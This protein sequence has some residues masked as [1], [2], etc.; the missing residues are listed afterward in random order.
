MRVGQNPA[1][2]VE[3]VVQPQEVT[4]AVVVCIPFLSG[5]FEESL[6]VLKA[7][8]SSI[9]ENT[10]PCYDLMVFDNASCQEVRDYLHTLSEKRLIQYLVFSEKNIGKMGAWNFIFGAAPGT[11]IAYAD[12]DIYFRSGWLSRS[13]ELFD[14][15]PKVGM[16][17]SRPMRTPDELS[18]STIE[19]GR[20]QGS[21]VFQEGKYLDWET[22]WEHTRSLGHSEEKARDEFDRGR[23]LMLT[24]N[25]KNAY[26]GAD[27][28]QFIARRD[29]IQRLIPIPSEKPLRGDRALDN[30]INDLKYLR[31]TTVEAY[32][33]HIGNRLEEFTSA[34]SFVSDKKTGMLKRLLWV[35]GI[36]HGL[37]WL[38]NRIFRLYFS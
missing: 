24:K 11:Y 12:S 19:W 28:Y 15:F 14:A 35:P 8:L 22:Y 26:I 37:L 17:T 36:R 33:Q 2:F 9:W 3:S 10:P 20:Q 5:F 21:E 38:H 32:V 30:A 29:L 1:K 34:Q 31:L 4:I 18:S 25:G 23:D 13:L 7:C 16:V 6:D 27:H